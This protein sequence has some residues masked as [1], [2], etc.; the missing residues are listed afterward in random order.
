MSP[1]KTIVIA[2]NLINSIVQGLRGNYSTYKEPHCFY[3]N[4]K[5]KFCLYNGHN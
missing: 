3:G 5:V 1:L 4:Q 2:L